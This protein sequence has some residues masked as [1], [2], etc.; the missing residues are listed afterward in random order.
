MDKKY[1]RSGLNF[2]S[3]KAIEE[4][5]EFI[6]ALGK[7]LCYGWYSYNPEIPINEREYNKE[8]VKRELDDALEALTRL[9]NEIENNLNDWHSWKEKQPNKIDYPVQILL[10][11]WAEP[12]V[13]YNIESTAKDFD[14]NKTIWRLYRNE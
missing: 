12:Q 9:K 8:W 5:G 13:I 10:P 3:T 2:A 14:L 4:C 11:G 6:S 1:I 7:T